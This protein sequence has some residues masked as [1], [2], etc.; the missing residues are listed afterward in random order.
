MNPDW[1]PRMNNLSVISL[2]TSILYLSTIPSFLEVDR[3]KGC[4]GSVLRGTQP[5]NFPKPGLRQAK[6]RAIMRVPQE[7]KLKMLPELLTSKHH[8]QNS[9][10]F[11]IIMEVG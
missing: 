1:V 8:V 9:P 11:K 3:S 6:Q 4:L 7:T 10:L 2:P 5:L